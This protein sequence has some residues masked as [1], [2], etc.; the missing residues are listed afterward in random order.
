MVGDLNSAAFSSDYGSHFNSVCFHTKKKKK[1]IFF[2]KETMK[3]E[4]NSIIRE[5]EFV[6][7]GVRI[8]YLSLGI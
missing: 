4:S 5:L 1:K 7:F 3:Y 2:S 8:A 6:Y